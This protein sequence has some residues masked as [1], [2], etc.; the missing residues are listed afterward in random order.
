[1]NESI[2]I[3][4]EVL[5]SKMYLIRNKKVMIDSDLALL[6]GV[7]TKRINE[8]CKRNLK[9]FPMDFMFQLSESEFENLKSQIATS[10]WGGRRSLPF[11]FT[12]K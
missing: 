3:P 11:V 6:Y 8:Q 1:M 4:D 10:K 7:E 5:I 12:E 2:M 9:R